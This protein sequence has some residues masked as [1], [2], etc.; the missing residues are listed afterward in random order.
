MASPQVITE[1]HYF[2][3]SATPPAGSVAGLTVN[4]VTKENLRFKRADNSTVDYLNTIPIGAT[5]INYSWRKHLLLY[6][7]EGLQGWLADLKFFVGTEPSANEETGIWED[8]IVLRCKTVDT[9]T[10]ASVADEHTPLSGSV[11]ATMAEGEIVGIADIDHPLP[12]WTAFAAAFAAAVPIPEGA[13]GGNPIPVITGANSYGFQLFVVL[14][15]GVKPG[16]TSD[17]KKERQL[18]Y[19]YNVT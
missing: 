19:R 11:I 15:I 2:T 10:P 9:Y 6:V 5:T 14:Q 4:V 3:G 8:Q 12:C 18:F 17:L 1:I 7:K 13:S 16:C